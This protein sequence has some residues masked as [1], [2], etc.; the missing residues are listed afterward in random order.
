[1]HLWESQGWR[2]VVTQERPVRL[3]RGQVRCWGRLEVPNCWQI[4]HWQVT[5]NLLF[6]FFW[7]T[8]VSIITPKKPAPSQ[9]QL[10]IQDLQK[11]HLIFCQLWLRLMTSH[12]I[13]GVFSIFAKLWTEP[14]YAL[15]AYCPV[16]RGGMITAKQMPL[17]LLICAPDYC[18]KT[19]V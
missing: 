7:F 17:S 6:S 2:S 14:Y 1:M 3:Q 4:K 13:L 18:F 8:L 5:I 12:I 19:D 10:T 15:I 16:W 11:P 9:L